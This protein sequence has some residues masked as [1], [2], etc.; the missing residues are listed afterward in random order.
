[1]DDAATPLLSEQCDEVDDFTPTPDMIDAGLHT[2]ISCCYPT[3]HV[4]SVSELDLAAVYI[5]MRRLEQAGAKLIVRG[6]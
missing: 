5:A 4:S 3:D 2:L 6:A 1:M